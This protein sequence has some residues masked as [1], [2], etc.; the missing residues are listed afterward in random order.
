MA[1]FH[2]VAWLYYIQESLTCMHG[3][4]KLYAWT[5]AKPVLASNS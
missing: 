2:F 4:L 5:E 3:I 1:H